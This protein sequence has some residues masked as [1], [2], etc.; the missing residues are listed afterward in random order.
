[1]RLELRYMNRRGCVETIQADTDWLD[2]RN[3]GDVDKLI[4]IVASQYHPAPGW[5]FSS[6]REDGGQW[7]FPKR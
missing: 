4:H 7:R 6:W 5:L 3:R 1:M 2:N